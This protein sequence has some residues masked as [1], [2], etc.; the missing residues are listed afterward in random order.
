MKK[1][2]SINAWKRKKNSS[3]SWYDNTT[4]SIF[5]F[6]LRKR[7]EKQLKIFEDQGEKQIKAIEDLEGKK[8]EAF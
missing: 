4:S 8:F 7:F 3:W 2:K 1:G 6:Q 5:Y